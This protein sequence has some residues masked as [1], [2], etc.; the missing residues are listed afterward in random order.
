MAAKTG[1]VLLDEF[2]HIHPCVQLAALTPQEQT[3]V[4]AD[5]AASDP[6]NS[7]DV[8]SQIERQALVND[9]QDQAAYFK[10]V[11][12]LPNG[13]SALCLSGGGIRSA[14]FSLGALQGLAR[15]KLLSQFDYLSTVSGGGYTGAWL[16][17]WAH[18]HAL[19]GDAA[20]LGA[21]AGFEDVEA[22]LASRPEHAPTEIG[23][24]RWLRRNQRFLNPRS[25][26]LSA[27]LWA[28]L[29][30]FLRDLLL[31]WL[32]YFPA[33][34]ALMLTPRLVEAG[35]ILWTVI[36]YDGGSSF[37]WAIVGSLHGF[38]S[39]IVRPSWPGFA[40]LTGAVLVLF[41]MS[42]AGFYRTSTKRPGLNDARFILWVLL[43]II[44]GALVLVAFNSAI[45]AAGAAPDTTL[46]NEWWIGVPFAFVAGRIIGA[47]VKMMV[48][49]PPISWSK[50]LTGFGL[51]LCCL[52]I[53]G[54][55]TGAVIFV[56]L[57]LHS[58]YSHCISSLGDFVVLG[59]PY[60]LIA[61]VLGQIAY[62]GLSNRFAFGHRD[63]EW[64]ARASGFYLLA[65]VVWVLI[66]GLVIYG[67]PLQQRLLSVLVVSGTAGTFTL[68]VATSTFS[69]ATAAFAAARERIPLR[70]LIQVGA[71]VF[72]CGGAIT[73]T[74]ATQY[75]IQH[76]GG[77]D[78][79]ATASLLS[80]AV[81]IAAL[82]HKDFSAAPVQ[83]AAAFFGTILLWTCG[84]FLTSFVL[85]LIIDVNAFSLHALYRN[86]LVR[87]FLGAT[88]PKPERNPFDG[89]SGNDDLYLD[90]LWSKVAGSSASARPQP[91]PPAAPQRRREG[92][93]PVINIALNLVGAKD[94]AWQE[95]KAAP[96][97]ATPLH[98]GA[99]VVGYIRHDRSAK[100]RYL[101]LG[102]AMAI[103]GAAASPNWGY[104]SSPLVGFLMM[105]F[106]IR[107]GWWLEN[108][109]RAR[110]GHNPFRSFRLFVQEA[111]GRTSADDAYVYLSDGGHFD[112]LGIYEML[113]RR[114]RLILAVDA[115]QDQ[116]YDFADLGRSLRL[117]AV[118]LGIGVEFAPIGINK[119]TDP[120]SPGVYAA[121]AKI[122]YPERGL[123]QGHAATL[124]Y[125][126]PG[127]FADA[128]ADVRAYAGANP[129]FPHDNTFNQWFT[130]SQ[131]ESYRALGAHVVAHIC[132]S[133]GTENGQL[134]LSELPDLVRTYLQA[135][136]PSGPARARPS[137]RK[138]WRTSG[139]LL[140]RS[141]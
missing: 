14:A 80:T 119:R 104:H 4:E 131:F 15:H 115:T 17:A 69:K 71:F 5:R 87:T 27:D 79:E 41:G 101:S 28:T 43:P 31:N 120:A 106:N 117:A 130:E 78:I 95:R 22:L 94:N 136:D 48:Q 61:F 107:L 72:V 34:A 26:F 140:S 23:P 9:A 82:P 66:S 98:V 121:I 97:V 59:V 56:G 75:L 19:Q 21:T 126:K 128:P 36:A 88:N 113:R 96:F 112:N 33:I 118:D 24:F 105:L 8:R 30:L 86:R 58:Q 129:A 111:L 42:V 11:H 76:I 37:G 135:A 81:R 110:T 2:S 84:L 54:F 133:E 91:E 83:P 7:A 77:L 10:N 12:A 13:Q 3:K 46:R 109:K 32:V 16:T 89:F 99:D 116:N 64:Q 125:L 40:D 38:S 49:G 70:F 63:R 67:Q 57:L 103:S 47:M 132:G 108:P 18:H 123:V 45:L 100:R 122:T 39:D 6:G 137:R 93:F 141:L 62:A 20:E 139:A 35:L 138:G 92:P 73:L 124:I 44:S 52:S 29:A 127:F 53:G 50:S 60:L 85:S 90:V 25:G 1:R 114:C 134:Q 55:V 74:A 68:A 51:E 65:S 102:T